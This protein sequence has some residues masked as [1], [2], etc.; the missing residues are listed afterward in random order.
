MPAEDLLRRYAELAVRIGANVQPGQV[1]NVWC[2]YEHAPLARALTVSC[3]ETGASYVDVS[4]AD[5]HVQREF[6]KHAPEE[7]LEWS[8]PWCFP[9]VEFLAEQ[10]GATISITGD[11]N[12]DIYGDLDGDRVGRA[13]PKE[14]IQRALEIWDSGRV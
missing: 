9:R 10:R 14:F 12:P 2:F 8:P 11:P 3:Y 13:R 4:Y 5:Q 7:L 6:L 1:V